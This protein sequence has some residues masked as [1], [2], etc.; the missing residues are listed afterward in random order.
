LEDNSDSLLALAPYAKL[1]EYDSKGKTLN[2]ENPQST[3]FKL[4]K[5]SKSI[6]KRL[7]PLKHL[8]KL[9]TEKKKKETVQQSEYKWKRYALRMCSY[10]LWGACLL[11]FKT[12][13][14]AV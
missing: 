13:P 14:V 9:G 1:K 10:A 2:G 4:S 6:K 8:K 5:G 3:L 12:L 7:L 11:L